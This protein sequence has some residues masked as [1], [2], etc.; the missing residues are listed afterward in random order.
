MRSDADEDHDD[1]QALLQR[2]HDGDRAA[3]LRLVDR[4]RAWVERRVRSR[5]G[6]LLQRMEE[7]VDGMQDLMLR[8]IDYAPRFRVANRAQ[9]RALLG[10]MLGNL[11]ADRARCLARQ[12]PPMTLSEADASRARVDL[13]ASEPGAA[14]ADAAAHAEELGWLRLGLEFLPPLE[15]RLIRARTF[16]ELG[17][18]DAGERVGLGAD[19]ARVRFRRALLKLAG[20]VQ[21]L[22]QGELDAMLDERDDDGG[23][24]EPS[25]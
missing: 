8:A 11:L 19:A 10:R 6:A 9:F 13:C 15:R 2:W 16:E 22:Q 24:D 18:D 14:P 17:F 7:T 3:L 25:T 12:P 4:D 5:R 23:G 20:V 1:T 21:R